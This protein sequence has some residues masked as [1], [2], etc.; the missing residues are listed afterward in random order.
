MRMH[1][2]MPLVGTKV[3]MCDGG[4]T[5]TATPFEMRIK[6]NVSA[7]IAVPVDAGVLSPSPTGGLM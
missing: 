6:W 2:R 1:A 5:T 7:V 3:E 4:S